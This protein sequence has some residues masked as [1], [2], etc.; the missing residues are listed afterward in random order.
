MHE[1]R[2]T[3]MD[4]DWIVFDGSLGT[5]VCRRCGAKADLLR[6][7]FTPGYPSAVA[8]FVK[9][10]SQCQKSEDT[11]CLSLKSQKPTT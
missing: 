9:F 8:G 2:T 5:C 10:H 11:S 3:G 7:R 4:V 6:F 1:T